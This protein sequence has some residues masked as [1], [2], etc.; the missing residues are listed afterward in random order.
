MRLFTSKHWRTTRVLCR[1]TGKLLNN[2]VLVRVW[3]INHNVWVSKASELRIRWIVGRFHKNHWSNPPQTRKHHKHNLTLAFI[4]I[5]LR[6]EL[7]SFTKAFNMHCWC[8]SFFRI[9]FLSCI[10]HFN[11]WH[12]FRL[13]R[14]AFDFVVV[15]FLIRNFSIG[16]LSRVI[17]KR[18]T[19]KEVIHVNQHTHTYTEKQTQHNTTRT[20]QSKWKSPKQQSRVIWNSWNSEANW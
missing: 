5:F 14:L 18:F 16:V 8:V 15:A 2:F 19:E 3:Q 11:R 4:W 17:G 7:Q 13:F 9:R 12:K 1:A 6:I 20:E 10:V